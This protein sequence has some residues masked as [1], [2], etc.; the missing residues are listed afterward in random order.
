MYLQ[1]CGRTWHQAGL[2]ETSKDFV[3]NSCVLPLWIVPIIKM[4][5]W[6]LSVCQ[7]IIQVAN[8][9]YS[10]YFLQAVLSTVGATSR[11]SPESAPRPKTGPGSR[12]PSRKARDRDTVT[13][14]GAQGSASDCKRDH[15]WSCHAR[16]VGELDARPETA[17]SRGT[18]PRP[19]P[20]SAGSHSGGLEVTVPV[21]AAR[22]R[23]ATQLS[24]YQRVSWTGPG[25]RLEGQC[26][27]KEGVDRL[28]CYQ[29]A[30]RS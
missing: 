12:S 28:I 7:C 15:G 29:K 19:A 2:K 13:G 26:T 3:S 4:R 14:T 30:A 21:L 27:R 9:G 6:P 1:V 18:E 5:L 25:L 11:F 16:A 20:A 23:T 17:G 24:D 8:M 22:C 10:Y